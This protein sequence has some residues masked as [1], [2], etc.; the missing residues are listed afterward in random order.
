MSAWLAGEMGPADKDI[1][2]S[3]FYDDVRECRDRR[4]GYHVWNIV[5]H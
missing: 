1:W 2:M 4:L 5:A 3:V